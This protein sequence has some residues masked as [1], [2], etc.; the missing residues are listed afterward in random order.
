MLETFQV[1]SSRLY[2]PLVYF[3]SPAEDHTAKH[4]DF[5]TFSLSTGCVLGSSP[6]FFF[7]S[8]TRILRVNS[9]LLDKGLVALA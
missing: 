4:L 1:K 7:F 2:Y 6:H 9:L 3:L 5:S 8:L